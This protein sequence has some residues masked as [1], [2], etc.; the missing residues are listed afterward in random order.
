M[1]TIIGISVT[2]FVVWFLIISM[3]DI[4]LKN[5]YCKWCYPFMRAI[6]V[7]VASCPC[8]L[9][10]A[11]PSVIVI[12]LNL[13]MKNSILIKTNKTF[14]NVLKIG[15]VVFDKTGTL[16]NKIE[17]ISEVQLLNDNFTLP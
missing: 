5:E 4:E 7:L 1:I 6:S 11:I 15:S 9:G 16:F 10:L 8:A 17:E 14:D 2:V 13:A 12:T 3:S